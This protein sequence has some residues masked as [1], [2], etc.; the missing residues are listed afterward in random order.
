MDTFTGW[1]CCEVIEP[2]VLAEAGYVYAGFSDCVT[3]F[4]CGGGLRSW[5]YGDE[6]WEEHARWFPKCMF[7]RE[8]NGQ[9]NVTV[10]SNGQTDNDERSE[11]SASGNQDER[12]DPVTQPDIPGPNLIYRNSNYVL[13]EETIQF[14]I[15]SL[16]AQKVEEKQIL[17]ENRRLRELITCKICLDLE[18]S[19]VFLP[20]GHLVS[21]QHCA[22]MLKT[23]AV[24]RANIQGRVM[25][26][27][28]D[29][30]RI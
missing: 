2:S 8:Q 16:E 20:C 3:C 6:P 27:R 9:M 21:C 24:C 30:R 26:M 4:S 11:G 19:I 5:Q 25:V 7:L 14:A 29:L 28:C 23:C 15:T 22:R 17:K 13:P 1:P 12:Y 18:A 10:R